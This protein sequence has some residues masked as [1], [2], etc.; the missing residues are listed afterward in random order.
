MPDLHAARRERL[1]ERMAALDVDAALITRPVNVRYLCGFTGSTSALLVTS[2]Q[3]VL[4]TDGRYLLQAAEQVPDLERTVEKRG[5]LALAGRAARAKVRRLG[6]ES[7]DV[8]VDTH[9]ELA[10]ALAGAEMV[11]AARVVEDLRRIKDETEISL[12]R[13][14][15]AIGDRALAELMDGLV[16]GRTERQ[17][18]QELE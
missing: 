14:A 18:A 8:T 13:E 17:I 16:L 7:H 2:D 9:G 12:L 11:S 5:A 1:R 4:A 6:F 15:C 3:A 10:E